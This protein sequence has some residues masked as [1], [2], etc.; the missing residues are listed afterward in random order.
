MQLWDCCPKELQT[1]VRNYGM[2]SIGIGFNIL[3]KIMVLK[4]NKKKCK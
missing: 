1:S 3:T 2:I 4:K